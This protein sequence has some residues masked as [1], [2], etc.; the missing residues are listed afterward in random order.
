GCTIRPEIDPTLCLYLNDAG[1]ASK[2]AGPA[3][4]HR[5]RRPR[6]MLENTGR[7][8]V[9]LIHTRD[10]RADSKRRSQA[11]RQEAAGLFLRSPCRGAPIHQEREPCKPLRSPP[12]F[13]KQARR[14]SSKNGRRLGPILLPM[15]LASTFRRSWL[16]M[17]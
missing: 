6:A 17:E 11:T 3:R 14:L 10:G 4:I 9:S 7:W 5:S 8:L 13:P 15:D 16:S 12:F 2:F 1:R